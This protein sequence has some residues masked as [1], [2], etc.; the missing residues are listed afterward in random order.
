VSATSSD[1]LAG[2]RSNLT[3]EDVVT[4]RSIV[5]STGFFNPAEI[6]IA[7]E[8]AV[9]RMKRGAASGYHFLLPADPGP[10]RGYACFGPIEATEGGFDLYWI[11]VHAQARGRGLGRRLLRAAEAG[12]RSLGGTR[13]WVETSSRE[14]YAPTRAFYAACGYEEVARLPDFYAPGDSKVIFV[15]RIDA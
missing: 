3:A 4:V 14:Q 12:A 9:E 2:F 8:L 13:L 5:E 1:A 6:E 15:R 11:A 10:P 7:V